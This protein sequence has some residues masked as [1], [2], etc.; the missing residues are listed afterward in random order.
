MKPCRRYQ[1]LIAWLV[2]DELDPRQ[3]ASV[4]SHLDECGACRGYFEEMTQLTGAL[5][6]KAHLP[7]IEASQGFHQR[8]VC[9]LRK[10]DSQSKFSDL[11]LECFRSRWSWRVALPAAGAVVLGVLVLFAPSHPANDSVRMPPTREVAAAQPVKSDFDPTISNYKMV[12]DQSFERLDQ[13]LTEQGRKNLTPTAI[14]TA[15]ARP[16]VTSTE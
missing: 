2:L 11:L 15:S 13:L 4:Q 5:K 8:L 3:K 10:T 1:K 14:Y 7:S 16:S 9:N 12:A 6:P